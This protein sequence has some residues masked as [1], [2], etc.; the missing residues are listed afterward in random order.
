MSNP[1]PTNSF[2][3]TKANGTQG[4]VIVITDDLNKV[5]TPEAEASLCCE[6][7]ETLGSV[8]YHTLPN[9]TLNAMISTIF[10][11][12]IRDDS[13]DQIDTTATLL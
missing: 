1:T 13:S 12:A 2:S 4:Q 8:L 5:C 10:R 3:I 11:C 6:E 7:G 9:K